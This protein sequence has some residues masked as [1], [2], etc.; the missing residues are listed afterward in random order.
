MFFSFELLMCSYFSA[1]PDEGVIGYTIARS[2]QRKDMCPAAALPSYI[3]TVAFLLVDTN[4]AVAPR[5]D[6]PLNTARV[7]MAN[8]EAGPGGPVQ[9]PKA[10]RVHVM[11][12]SRERS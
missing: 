2:E 10:S 3:A 7:S 8:V 12:S 1:M 9:N 6:I 11:R 5:C 4:R